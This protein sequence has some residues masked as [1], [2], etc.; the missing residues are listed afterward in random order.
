MTDHFSH[1]GKAVRSRQSPS[2]ESFSSS[3]FPKPPRSTKGAVPREGGGGGEGAVPEFPEKEEEEEEEREL[4]RKPP[5]TQIIFLL[6][7][8][9]YI[10]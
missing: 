8:S 1:C 4:S 10:M 9:T 6:S 7:I 3:G 2:A 5:C